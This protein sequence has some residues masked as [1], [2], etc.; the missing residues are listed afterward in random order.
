MMAA[1]E[2]A[3]LVVGRQAERPMRVGLLTHHWV[4]NFG[5]NLQALSL[6][7][8]LQA[9]GHR[10]EFINY[11]PPLLERYYRD[12]IGNEQ[13][14]RHEEFCRELLPQGPVLRSLAEVEDYQRGAGLEVL[15]AGSDAILRLDR[16]GAS[17]DLRFPNPFWLGRSNGW[18]GRRP[19]T[20]YLAASA[21]GANY[22]ADPPS[23][24]LGV[25]RALERTDFISVRDRWTRMMLAAVS[26]GRV[27]ARL[28]PDPVSVLAEVFALPPGVQDGPAA[29]ARRYVLLSCSR[30]RLKPAWVREFVSLAHRS[31]L[32]VYSLPRL[33]EKRLDLPVDRELHLPM[34][35]L[36]WYAWISNAAGYVGE[37]FHAVACSVFSGVPFVSMDTYTPTFL[38]RFRLPYAS[39]TYDLCMNMG[40][41]SRCIPAKWLHRQAPAKVMAMLLNNDCALA[42]AYRLQAKQEFRQ[43]VDIALGASPTSEKN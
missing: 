35:P 25:R 4:A 39:K 36:E 16:N 33:P 9:R 43:V 30:R 11:R 42:G 37:L 5:A 12:H 23:W 32:E 1:P 27:R 15:L 20:A 10:A 6:C 8:A 3:A 38:R 34:S 26:L 17:E 41:C 31:G 29:H 18:R 13:L 14:A 28:C 19:R 7:R 2:Q 40:A 22:L 24:Q 21:M